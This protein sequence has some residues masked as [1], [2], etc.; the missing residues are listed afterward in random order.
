LTS[1]LNATP[2]THMA[3]I[4]ATNIS[5]TVR[6]SFLRPRKIR[7]VT[8]KALRMFMLPSFAVRGELVEL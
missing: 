2:K 8:L 5:A 1:P 3:R 7:L 4:G 6:L